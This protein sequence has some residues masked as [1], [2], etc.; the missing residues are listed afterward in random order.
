MT[1]SYFS[2][3]QPTGDDAPRSAFCR[4]DCRTSA[5]VNSFDAG[6]LQQVGQ[7]F[8][9]HPVIVGVNAENIGLRQLKYLQRRQIG[10]TLNDDSIARI[11][12][13]T[14]NDIQRLLGAG[15]DI[16]RA[17]EQATPREWQFHS[18]PGAA[19]GSLPSDRTGMR[20]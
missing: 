11:E 3:A 18:P 12:Q 2:P 20:H 17:A 14:G 16:D 15:G 10:G 5:R 8:H 9:Q 7:L 19:A 13:R 1:K 4:Q 6:G